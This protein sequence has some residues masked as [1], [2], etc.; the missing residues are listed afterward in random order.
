MSTLLNTCKPITTA[1]DKENA[2]NTLKNAYI[3]TAVNNYPYNATVYRP[4]EANPVN[5]SCE[6]FG[7]LESS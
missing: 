3:Q 5:V 4:M 6:Y 7:N 2:I 1:D